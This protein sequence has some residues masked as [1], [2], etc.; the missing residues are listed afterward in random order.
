[1]RILAHLCLQH[2]V[3]LWC[4]ETALEDESASKLSNSTHGVHCMHACVHVHSL[5]FFLSSPLLSVCG[6]CQKAPAQHCHVCAHPMATCVLCRA[7]AHPL[8]RMHT[9]RACA[10]PRCPPAALPLRLPGFKH[11]TK[12]NVAAPPPPLLLR[13]SVDWLLL[14][15]DERGG[16]PLRNM[17]HCSPTTQPANDSVVLIHK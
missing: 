17:T 16:P 5:L 1:M 15:F 4:V 13:S 10:L 2:A 9:L 11:G 8:L 6:C 3:H 14:S 7:A 12:Q